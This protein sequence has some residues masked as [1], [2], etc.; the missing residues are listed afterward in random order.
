MNT[1]VQPGR[2][3]CLL[4]PGIA[5]T[6]GPA[7]GLLPRHHYHQTALPGTA[8]RRADKAARWRKLF[9]SGRSGL[10][11][12]LLR[13]IQPRRSSPAGVEP[14]RQ[15]RGVCLRMTSRPA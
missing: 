10:L 11:L 2:L 9:L 13:P 6:R 3:A 12:G 7:G 8:R 15:G 1:I 5:R 4:P 14:S